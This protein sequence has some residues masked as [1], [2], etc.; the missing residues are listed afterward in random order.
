M[1]LNHY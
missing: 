1:F